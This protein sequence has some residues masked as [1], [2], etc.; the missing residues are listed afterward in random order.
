MIRDGPVN[1]GTKRLVSPKPGTEEEII[2]FTVKDPHK[3]RAKGEILYT[4]KCGT[5]IQ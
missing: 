4:V 3:Q 5:C 2:K 1:G